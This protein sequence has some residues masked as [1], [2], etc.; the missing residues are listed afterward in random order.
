MKK[1]KIKFKTFPIADFAGVKTD[2]IKVVIKCNHGNETKF[3]WT[4]VKS[5]FISLLNRND[6]VVLEVNLVIQRFKYS[7]SFAKS[8]KLL[9]HPTLVTLRYDII[10]N[11]LIT[12]HIL[13][14][15]ILNYSSY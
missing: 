4:P 14:N 3:V 13:Y 1:K 10:T 8:Q 9:H 15:V 12:M 6:A 11:A 7:N 2:T 5:T